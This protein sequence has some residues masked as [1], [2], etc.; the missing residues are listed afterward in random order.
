MVRTSTKNKNDNSDNLFTT[1]HSPTPTTTAAVKNKRLSSS[2]TDSPTSITADVSPN[3]NSPPVLLSL[4]S[5]SSE[6]SQE[7]QQSQVREQYRV[8]F[9]S[10]VTVRKTLSHRN[11]SKKEKCNYWLQEDEFVLIKQQNDLMIQQFNDNNED[12]LDNNEYQGNSQSS[13]L[14]FTKSSVHYGHQHYDDDEDED[15]KRGLEYGLKVEAIRKRSS[16]YLAL[17]EV[18]IKQEEQYLS[19]SGS[20]SFNDSQSDYFIYDDEAIADAYYTIS[21]ECQHRAHRIAIQ[22]RKEIEYYIM[23]SDSDNDIGASS[24]GCPALRS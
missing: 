3:R 5:S 6:L 9:F 22:D 16:R 11:M 18:L 7:S 1:F 8:R 2:S 10:K 4:Q 15:C 13:L 19:G 14:S 21:Y 23:Y 20:G 24:N 17:E 12:D